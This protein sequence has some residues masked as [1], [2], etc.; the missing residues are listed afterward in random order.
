MRSG[1]LRLSMIPYPYPPA[2]YQP[3]R[4]RPTDHIII[5]PTRKRAAI[6]KRPQPIR[7]SSLIIHSFPLLKP[8]RPIQPHH[9][10]ALNMDPKNDVFFSFSA[11][12]GLRSLLSL[13]RRRLLLC[14]RSAGSSPASPTSRR[15]A[16]G[17]SP[18]SA[19]PSRLDEIGCSA[20]SRLPSPPLLCERLGLSPPRPDPDAAEVDT[21]VGSSC[22]SGEL[23]LPPATWLSRLC[24][25]GN[26]PEALASL[27]V[28]TSNP[29]RVTLSPVVEVRF[30]GIAGKRILGEGIEGISM[31][32]VGAGRSRSRSWR[33]RSLL[34]RVRVRVASPPPPPPPAAGT[35]PLSLRLCLCLEAAKA[36][37]S[38]SL[39]LTNLLASSSAA[40]TAAFSIFFCKLRSFSFR[41]RSASSSALRARRRRFRSASSSAVI[42]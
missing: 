6:I 9:L 22:N 10:N 5:R 19:L 13:S 17:L 4:Y 30:L 42:E 18:P 23:V 24:L 29:A 8:L 20:R 34:L 33:C 1:T 11:T 25:R 37:F 27:E 7:H 32:A 28:R 15:T 3:S 2:L 12:T 36:N 39:F 40:L 31:E 35:T 21:A 26:S 16:R 38:S 14:G 41:S